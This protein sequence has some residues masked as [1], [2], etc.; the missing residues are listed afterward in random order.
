MKDEQLLL[1][2]LKDCR[3]SNDLAIKVCNNIINQVHTNT[4]PKRRFFIQYFNTVLNAPT[5]DLPLFI[6]KINPL[7]KT[8]AKWRLMTGN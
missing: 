1:D 7:E 3:F 5:E 4:P 2:L 8:I 6:N